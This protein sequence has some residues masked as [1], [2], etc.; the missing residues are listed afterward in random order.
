MEYSV[1]ASAGES[2]RHPDDPEHHLI[3]ESAAISEICSLIRYAAATEIPVMITGPSGCGKE[4]VAKALHRCSARAGEK[5]VGVNCGAI[6]RD[7][8][9]SELFGHE[10]GSFTGAIAQRKGRFED[11]SEGTLFLDEIG[12]MPFDM[13]VKLLRVLEEKTIERIGGNQPI[14]INSRIISATHQNLDQAIC[15]KRFREDLFYRL[16]VFPIDIPPLKHRR[17]D[18]APL[19]DH[20]LQPAHSANHRIGFSNGAMQ[21]LKIYDWPGNVR[22]LRNIVERAGLLFPGMMISEAQ[23]SSLFRRRASN[24]PTHEVESMQVRSVGPS[25]H[26]PVSRLRADSAIPDRTAFDQGFDLKKHLQAEE[27]RLMLSAL[28]AAAGVVSEAAELV[29]L[30]RT[31]F[32][33]KMKRHKIKRQTIHMPAHM[34]ADEH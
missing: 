17:E 32:V 11:A 27:R 29:N 16:S 28:K 34:S 4:V 13:Q 8:L 31:T 21:R 15:S 5:F 14:K 2:V 7:L 33:E 22:E 19:I 25:R 30:R 26:E 3:G 20:F 10:K 18:I 6:P 12:D 1:T 24:S 23:V 9:E